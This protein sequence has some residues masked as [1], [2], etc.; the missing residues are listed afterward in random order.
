APTHCLDRLADRLQ[1]V[2]DVRVETIP[3]VRR[4]R[5]LFHANRSEDLCGCRLVDPPL[6]I[7]LRR[8]QRVPEFRAAIKFFVKERSKSRRLLLSQGWISEVQSDKF[9][10]PLGEWILA[11]FRLCRNAK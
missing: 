4:R 6:D 8:L 1:F 3:P 2:D 11:T 7:C 5:Y 9:S 10:K